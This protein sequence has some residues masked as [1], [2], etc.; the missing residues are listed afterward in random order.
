MELDLSLQVENKKEG[1]CEQH[2]A[3]PVCDIA[4]CIMLLMIYSVMYFAVNLHLQLGHCEN[5]IILRSP[6]DNAQSLLTMLT[7]STCH[8]M[9][10][11][12]FYGL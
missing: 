9:L 11:W 7:L 6:I 1:K 4:K 3:G 8:Y 10:I 5:N 12:H 2:P